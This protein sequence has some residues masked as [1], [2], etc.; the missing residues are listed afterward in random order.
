ME[1]KL[2]LLNRPPLESMCPYT[3]FHNSSILN[4]FWIKNF[5]N[6]TLK[7]N[8]T[9]RQERWAYVESAPFNPVRKRGTDE[10]L[11]PAHPNRTL[12]DLSNL[13]SQKINPTEILKRRSL[14]LLSFCT[15]LQNPFIQLPPYIHLIF[16][17]LPLRGSSNCESIICVVNGFCDSAFRLHAEWQMLYLNMI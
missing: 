4:L 7:C 14:L 3:T 10:N 1:L 2:F 11:H 17:S 13:K 9:S 6:S 12:S 5:L 15:K 16:S 8:F